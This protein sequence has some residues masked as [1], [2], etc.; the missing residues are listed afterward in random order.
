MPKGKRTK[1]GDIALADVMSSVNA[2]RNLNTAIKALQKQQNAL[3]DQALKNARDHLV[4]D[5]K[6]SRMVRNRILASQ[7]RKAKKSKK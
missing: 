2:Q 1:I 7:K 6:A 5:V 4:T 3:A